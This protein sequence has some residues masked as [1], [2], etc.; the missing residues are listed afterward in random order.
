MI[1]FTEKEKAVIILG[2]ASVT[3]ADN[4]GGEPNAREMEFFQLVER[5]IRPTQVAYDLYSIYFKN[6]V[7]A[8]SQIRDI[9]VE[10]KRIIN[11]L[12]VRMCAC[13]GPINEGEQAAL[14]LLDSL[15]G[16]PYMSMSEIDSEFNNLFR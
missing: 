7:S 5:T 13:D 3:E 1:S 6:P 2:T 11:T 10:K 14:D 9:S 8:Y 4:Y 15:C 12:F 16:F